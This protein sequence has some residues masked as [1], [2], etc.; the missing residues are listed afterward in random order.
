MGWV[1]GQEAVRPNK[2]VCLL[3]KLG[4]GVG[5]KVRTGICSLQP[6][7]DMCIFA[8]VTLLTQLPA[9]QSP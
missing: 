3:G 2:S 9:L 8:K 7:A 6:T 5:Y 4:V 1:A